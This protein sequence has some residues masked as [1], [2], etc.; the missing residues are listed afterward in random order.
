MRRRGATTAAD[1]VD[2]TAPGKL[3]DHLRHCFGR[4]VVLAELVRQAGVGMRAD[5][6]IGDAREFIDVRAQVL[7]AE[8]AVEPDH[9]GIDMAHR[10][11][12]GFSRLAGQRAARRVRDRARYHHGQRDA[13]LLERPPD[14]K[15]RGLGIQRIEDRLDHQEVDAALDQRSRRLLIG[16][17]EIG[18]V[19]VAVTGVVDVG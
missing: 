5:A 13:G 19:D 16:R 3:A 7:R 15:D 12:E 4:L 14:C 6:R 8:R 10:I 9:E 18:E 2:E 17:G 1:Q 11:P